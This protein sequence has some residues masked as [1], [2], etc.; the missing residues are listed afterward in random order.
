M[1]LKSMSYGV[2][3]PGFRSQLCHFHLI[4]M[5]PQAR[6]W[7]DLPQFPYLEKGLIAVL[8]L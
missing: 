6:Y 3:V 7:L 8:T 2:T 1:V 4:A 5:E